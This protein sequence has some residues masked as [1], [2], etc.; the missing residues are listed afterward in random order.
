[1]QTIHL[2]VNDKIFK[3]LMW[4]LGRFNKE[5]I[6]LIMGNNEFLSIQEYLIKELEKIETGTSEFI[7]IDQLENELENT[8]QKYEG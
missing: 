6:Q 1:M 7:S 2:R 3:N 8:I 4:F 5:E